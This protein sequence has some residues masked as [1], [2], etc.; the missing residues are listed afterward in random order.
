MAE[1]TIKE[2]IT[3]ELKKIPETTA[4]TTINGTDRVP[5]SDPAGNAK[6]ISYT[7]FSTPF[8]QGVLN[9][10]PSTDP[11]LYPGVNTYNVSES[12]TYTH[13]D[14]IEVSSGDM[15][16]GLVQ[17]RFQDGEWQKVILPVGARATE[18][19]PDDIVEVQTGKSVS[20]WILGNNTSVNLYTKSV[21]D[22]DI[23][24]SSINRPVWLIGNRVLAD[25]VLKKLYIN[26]VSAGTIVIKRYKI[27]SDTLIFQE[28]FSYTTL[29]G[30]NEID[31]SVQ[32]TTGGILNDNWEWEQDDIMCLYSGQGIRTQNTDE[33]FIGI[34]ESASITG[35]TTSDYDISLL[36]I[37]NY[38]GCVAGYQFTAPGGVVL[39]DGV[40]SRSLADST[41]RNAL[42][43]LALRDYLPFE[44]DNFIRTYDLQD[45]EKVGLRIYDIDKNAER[46]YNGSDWLPT[47]NLTSR[48]MES[49]LFFSWNFE[50]SGL[51]KSSNF[52]PLAESFNV[53]N[54]YE[55]TAGNSANSALLQF[56]VFPEVGIHAW[57][58][59][60]EILEFEITSIGATALATNR[61]FGILYLGE[62]ISR[63][64]NVFAGINANGFIARTFIDGF[65]NV[66]SENIGNSLSITTGMKLRIEN[67]F[68]GSG[69]KLRLFDISGN[70]PVLISSHTIEFPSTGNGSYSH[71]A[72]NRI[73]G[74]GINDIGVKM[75]KYE[76]HNM[77]PDRADLVCVGDSITVSRVATSYRRGWAK[78]L[79]DWYGPGAVI[80]GGGS[81]TCEDIL[82]VINDI[83]EL[84]PKVVVLAIGTNDC[85]LNKPNREAEYQNIVAQLESV[86]IEVVLSNVIPADGVDTARWGRIN[87]FNSWIQSTYGSTN[88]IVDQFSSLV[89]GTNDDWNP[90][91][92]GDEL[93]PNDLGHEIMFNNAKRAI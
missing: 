48:V 21:S 18:L 51:Q 30:Y 72:N 55:I 79:C 53:D 45:R 76:V 22:F 36:N 80:I 62:T 7:D 46:I 71:R 34:A 64:V 70:S 6:N 26:V 39:D 86:G 81:N 52:N 3:L 88:K 24:V 15:A 65:T 68:V 61:C 14:G 32:L 33:S 16:S 57:E 47:G 58:M 66:T 35:N 13:F 8:V 93:H 82:N 42:S 50:N 83:K 2:G 1:I 9:A 25:G 31:L 4:V 67:Y 59:S 43:K 17:L 20:T 37:L 40:I 78:S 60:K 11:T 69:R 41:N 5:V 28:H 23:Y 73:Y 85:N 44:S 77:M 91:Y 10:V 92:R 89:N 19:D 84:R 49:G 75:T 74:I 90:E 29:E 38:S 27:V 63:K 56:V 12:G 87:D 54:S